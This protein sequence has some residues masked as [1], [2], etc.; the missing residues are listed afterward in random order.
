MYGAYWP[1]NCDDRY[2]TPKFTTCC[3]ES[4]TP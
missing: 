2:G 4:A 1:M 3:W